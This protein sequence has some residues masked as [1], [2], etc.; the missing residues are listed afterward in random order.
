MN[1]FKSLIFAIVCF[2]FMLG[3]CVTTNGTGTQVQVPAGCEDS[4]FYK[5]APWS[6]NTMDTGILAFQLYMLKNPAVKEQV[7]REV[8]LAMTILSSQMPTLEALSQL[9][10]L[11]L[12]LVGTLHIIYPS[13]NT[14]INKCDAELIMNYLKRLQ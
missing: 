2:A 13:T 9:S 11:D 14:T 7:Q 6:F 3:G 4:V 1:K 8:K 5:S 10:D 12:L